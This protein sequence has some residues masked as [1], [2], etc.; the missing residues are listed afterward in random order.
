LLTR[1]FGTLPGGAVIGTQARILNLKGAVLFEVIDIGGL[2][3]S[4]GVG[5]DYFDMDLAVTSTLASETVDAEAPVPMVFLQG[6]MDIGPASFVVEG[7]YMEA[8]LEDAKGRFWDLEAIV[9]VHLGKTFHAFG[10][11]R[12]IDIAAKGEADGQPFDTNL[13]MRGWML[14]GGFRF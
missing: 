8:H 14:G 9:R 10:G 6:E 3:L 2:K 13:E 7:G 1:D 11:Y 5:V 12:Y 4:P